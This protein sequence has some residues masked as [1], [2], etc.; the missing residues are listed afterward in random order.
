MIRSSPVR[1]ESHVM[2]CYV[3]G[4]HFRS[5][6]HRHYNVVSG[7]ISGYSLNMTGRNDRSRQT[8]CGSTSAKIYLFNYCQPRPLTDVQQSNRH[9][10]KRPD[11]SGSDLRLSN[12]NK[13][14]FGTKGRDGISES[15]YVTYDVSRMPFDASN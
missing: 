10:V 5:S 1:H 14:F 8:C 3:I 7:R 6:L 9:T 2:L 4:L 15:V 13:V 11:Y 12:N